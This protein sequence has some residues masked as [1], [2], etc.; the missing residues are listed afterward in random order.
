[1]LPVLFSITVPLNS[2]TAWHQN[3]KHPKAL[4]T[5]TKKVK[6]LYKL[7]GGMSVESLGY[8]STIC[9][10]RKSERKIQANIKASAP[11]SANVSQVRK[12]A[13]NTEK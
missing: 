12:R 4:V 7:H 2:S 1:V 11:I 13:P 5:L 6:I 10:I 9:T 8:E 3:V